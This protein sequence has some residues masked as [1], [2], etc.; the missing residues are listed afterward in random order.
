MRKERLGEA[1]GGTGT[2]DI[3]GELPPVRNQYMNICLTPG[4]VRINNIQIILH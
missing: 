1:M 4:K 2:E 3:L